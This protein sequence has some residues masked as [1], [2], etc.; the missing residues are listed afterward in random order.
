MYVGRK[1]F[2]ES[3]DSGSEPESSDTESSES[4]KM[5]SDSESSGN[6]YP[7]L[8]PNNE[9]VLFLIVDVSVTVTRTR[10]RRR[11]AF[12]KSRYGGQMPSTSGVNKQNSKKK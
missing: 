3:S 8:L 10:P 5:S 9:I 7:M 2:G 12:E 1:T 4:S 11:E 6:L